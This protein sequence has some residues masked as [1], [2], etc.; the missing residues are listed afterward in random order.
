MVP[1]PPESLDVLAARLSDAIVDLEA[2]RDEA[3]TKA[4]RRPIN[5]RLRSARFLLNW[6][7]SRRGYPLK[8]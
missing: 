4:E 7:Q 6:L 5:Q 3:R 1:E 2:E 8:G